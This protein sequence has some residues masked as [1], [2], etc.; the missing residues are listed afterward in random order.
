MIL[1]YYEE[2]YNFSSS[3]FGLNY[4]FKYP[5][6]PDEVEDILYIKTI[7]DDIEGL[8]VNYHNN[9]DD[10]ALISRIDYD[11][12]AKWF[13]V[14]ELTGNL[15]PNFFYVLNSRNEK[16]IM[17]PLWDAEWSL[18][19]ACKGNPQNSYEW[20][21]WPEHE[22]MQPNDI[23]WESQKYFKYLF[24]SPVFLKSLQDNWKKIAPNIREKQKELKELP[25]LL[26]FSQEDNFIRWPILDEVLGGE[27]VVFGSWD[28]EV[29]YLENW[30]DERVVW[31]D[32]YISSLGMSQF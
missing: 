24:K 12:F 13:I 32:G 16:L 26:T 3:L 25:K 6:T 18:G 15:D 27:L 23:Y 20:Y 31:F 9:S 17:G 22:P 10:D 19:L 4:S 30:F 11:S 1:I 2:P 8:L 5:K 7:I 14:S 28:K 21:W 29:S